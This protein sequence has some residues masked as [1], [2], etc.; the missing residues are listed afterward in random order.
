MIVSSGNGVE[1]IGHPHAEK[2]AGLLSYS[3]HN[4]PLKSG[5]WTWIYDLKP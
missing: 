3:L 2:E 4:N 5:F 1:K